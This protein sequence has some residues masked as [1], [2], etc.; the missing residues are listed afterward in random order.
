MT[1]GPAAMT[2]PATNLS[3]A[4]ATPSSSA[5]PSITDLPTNLVPSDSADGSSSV[6]THPSS[7]P[8]L[9]TDAALPQNGAATKNKGSNPSS[10]V[11]LGSDSHGRGR[12]V[13]KQPTKPS[14]GLTE[15]GGSHSAVATT[16]PAVA[17]SFHA[18]SASLTSSSVQSEGS[19]A[20]VA[21][22]IVQSAGSVHGPVG[23]TKSE[24]DKPKVVPEPEVS[25]C[26]RWCKFWDCFN[27]ERFS[28]ACNERFYSDLIFMKN[29]IF[30]VFID[31]DRT[32]ECACACSVF[33][34]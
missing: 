30:F 31:I 24:A 22:N 25:F 26:R 9:A 17:S 29:Y 5:S 4:S 12:V 23:S 1:A 2:K 21:S 16:S 18:G 14:S 15:G 6:A 27:F 32:I 3:S 19:V 20:A 10:R 34:I 11:G 28:M 8:P 13:E 7:L 33:N